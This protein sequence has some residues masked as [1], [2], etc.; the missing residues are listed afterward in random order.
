MMI[1]YI[2]QAAKAFYAGLVA[3]LGALAAIL[4]GS[5][6]FTDIT[7]GQWVA[8]ALATLVAFGGVYGISNRP[9]A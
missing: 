7:S 4:V 1:T 5:V 6:G 2:A 9:A 3:G 8:V